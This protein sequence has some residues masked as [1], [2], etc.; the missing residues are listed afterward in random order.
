MSKDGEG[1]SGG[2][3]AQADGQFL[4][5]GLKPGAY[6][7]EAWAKNGTRARVE[8]RAGDTNLRIQLKRQ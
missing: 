5:Y 7:I 4:M 8:A 1:P 2:V 3:T 6:R